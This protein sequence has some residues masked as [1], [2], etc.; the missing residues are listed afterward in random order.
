M[1]TPEP[2]DT[3]KNLYYDCLYKDDESYSAECKEQHIMG[4]SDCKWYKSTSR[5]KEV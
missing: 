3:C 5:K 1:N 2:C 4:V